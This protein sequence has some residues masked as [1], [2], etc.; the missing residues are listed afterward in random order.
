MKSILLNFMI[1]FFVLSGVIH[2]A[3]PAMITGKGRASGEVS[4]EFNLGCDPDLTKNSF[5]LE[6]SAGKFEL[7]KVTNTVCM[8][9]PLIKVP[10][11]LANFD[12]HKGEG[13]GFFN[14]RDGALIRWTL[15]DAGAIADAIQVFVTDDT[16]KIVLEISGPITVGDNQA[17]G[18]ALLPEEPGI[19]PENFVHSVFIDKQG[20]PSDYG[21]TPLSADAFQ[22]RLGPQK[23][24]GDPPRPV[25]KIHKALEKEV[26]ERD[27]D[28]RGQIVV[29]LRDFEFMPR[30]PDLSMEFFDC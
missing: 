20:I 15:T 28:D 25:P 19:D 4:F 7:K 8:D 17:R 2:A 1:L 24:A 21:R 5:L 26:A 6:W 11:P 22:I 23:P 18:D 9:D 30:F 10:D 13:I 12:T 29:N 27:P 16:G 3:E 14:G